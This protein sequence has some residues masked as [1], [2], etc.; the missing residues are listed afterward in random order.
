MFRLLEVKVIG[1]NSF[2]LGPSPFRYLNYSNLMNK[3]NKMPQLNLERFLS[4][5][6][7]ALI[8]AKPRI[9]RL[10]LKVYEAVIT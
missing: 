8:R 5:S 9:F 1:L 2:A 3:I 10:P 7:T 6:K 4:L